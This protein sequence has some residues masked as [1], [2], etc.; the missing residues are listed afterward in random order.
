M[1]AAS[2]KPRLVIVA[3]DASAT[4][5]ANDQVSNVVKGGNV[6][7]GVSIMATDHVPEDSDIFC[8]DEFGVVQAQLTDKQAQDLEAQSGVVVVED[9]ET[10][11]A[12]NEGFD[13]EP[14]DDP[15]AT[16][17]IDEA[18]EGLDDEELES[19][20]ENAAEQA[21]LASQLDPV[22]VDE[23]AFDELGQVISLAEPSDDPEIAG[24]P[25]E[26]LFRL[27]RCVIK[28]A[29][30]NFGGQVAQVSDEQISELL[31]AED[32]EAGSARAAA[33][34]DY[35]TCGLRIIWAPQAWRYSR[36]RGVRMAIVDTGIAPRHWDLR[37]RGGASF[38]PG[39][40]R[41][42]DDHGHGTHV[43][44]TVAAL[45]NNRGVV[46]VAPDAY[47]YAVKVLNGRGS[48]QISWIL[49]GLAWC[50]RTRMHIVNL[51][52]GSGARNH[53]P[54]EYS[55]AYEA[56]GVAMRRANILPVAAAGNSGATTRPFV[57]NPARC[58]SFMAVS[59]IDCNRRRSP[60]SSYGP[61]VEICAP[62]SAVWSTYPPA[63][64]RQLSGTS[65]ASP[66][67]AG[68]AALVKYRYPHW[69]AD[70]IRTYL[71]GTALDLGAPGKDW[72]FG[73]GQV[74]ALRAVL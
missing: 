70:T 29:I 71:W 55:R 52:L 31:A 53:N 13:D 11:Y 27:I 28:C 65:M 19:I 3:E 74:N 66:H 67:V 50:I 60:F 57:G 69:H 24:I 1:A 14:M 51:S 72:F 48:G 59:S 23:I 4:E 16:A 9:D 61:Q 45:Q 44:G 56:A 5:V 68:V 25:R 32:L 36:G 62:G 22:P 30:D 10:V 63:T 35:I 40:T 41:W 17:M 26:K 15:D 38:V 20:E 54:T 37:V 39:V 46:G 73:H 18:L 6:L 64:F 21:M 12:L 2:A 7:D 43:A 49:N 8:N 42:W 33:I 34:R 58:P 47:L